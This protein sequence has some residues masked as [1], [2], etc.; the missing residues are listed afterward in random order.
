MGVEKT[1]AGL[2]TASPKLLAKYDEIVRG[3]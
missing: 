3:K 2:Y 1:V